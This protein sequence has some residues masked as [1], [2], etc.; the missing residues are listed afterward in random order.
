MSSWEWVLF[1]AVYLVA[2]FLIAVIVSL[3]EKR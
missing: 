3:R 1:S 2:G